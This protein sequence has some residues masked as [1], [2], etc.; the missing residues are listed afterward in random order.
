MAARRRSPA[1]CVW[2]EPVEQFCLSDVARF[3]SRLR[4]RMTRFAFKGGVRKAVE[5]DLS[6][7]VRRV[8]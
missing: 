2:T 3:M 1:E 6:R 4:R 5:K 7:M 8:G